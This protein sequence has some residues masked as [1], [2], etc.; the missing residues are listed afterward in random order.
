MTV[1]G[2]QGEWEPGRPQCY[3]TSW[4]HLPECSKANL[5][6]PGCGEGKCS[7]N[8][9][10]ANARRTGVLCSK[11]PNSLEDFSKTILKASLWRGVAGYEISW[12]TILW[13]MVR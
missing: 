13:L 6:T 1:S 9:K 3:R 5:L 10:S 7:F 2:E 11:T 12:C 8:C 4:V